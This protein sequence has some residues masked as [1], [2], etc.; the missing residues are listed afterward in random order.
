M[1]QCSVGVGL[2]E[3]CQ[4][5]NGALQSRQELKAFLK[6]FQATSLYGDGVTLHLSIAAPLLAVLDS[7]HSMHKHPFGVAVVPATTPQVNRHR[8]PMGSRLRLHLQLPSPETRAGAPLTG[9]LC[10][11]ATLHLTSLWPCA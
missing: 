4:H 3:A 8:L 7:A 1:L 10:M 11:C 2:F 6:A 5:C 9:C